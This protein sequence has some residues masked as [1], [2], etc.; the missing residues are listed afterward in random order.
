MFIALHTTDKQLGVH[1]CWLGLLHTVDTVYVKYR[2]SLSYLPPIPSHH[3]LIDQGSPV[4]NKLNVCDSKYLTTILTLPHR[5][6]H[7]CTHMPPPPH[8]HTHTHLP[9]S[10]QALNLLNMHCSIIFLLHII[11]VFSHLCHFTQCFLEE[12]RRGK[13]RGGEGRRGKERGKGKLKEGVDKKE[14]RWS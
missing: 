14:G 4:E 8:T 10:N 11:D 2:L 13:K 12:G 5:Q 1:H 3:T 9:S 6:I 7:A